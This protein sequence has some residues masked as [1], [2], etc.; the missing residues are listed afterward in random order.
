MNA[1]VHASTVITAGL[2][3]FNIV[4]KSF[5]LSDASFNRLPVGKAARTGKRIE[6]LLEAEILFFK[7][8]GQISKEPC[9]NGNSGCENAKSRSG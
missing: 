6:F 4:N 8:N 9:C 3:E 7:H 1:D 5:P 2:P